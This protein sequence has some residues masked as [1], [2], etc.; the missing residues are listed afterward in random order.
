[1]DGGI[2]IDNLDTVLDS[3]VNVIVAGTGVFKGNLYKN[4]DSF[5]GKFKEHENIVNHQI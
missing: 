4:V 2:K 3:G 1:M 5:Y